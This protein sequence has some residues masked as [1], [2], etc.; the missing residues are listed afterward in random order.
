MQQIRLSHSSLE[1]LHTCE[2][3]FQ[4]DKLI[5]TDL[6]KEESEH[7][8]F[9]T[10][11]GV[12]IATYLSTAD[13]SLALYKAWLAYWPEIE[14]DGKNVPLLLHTLKLA[15]KECD[16]LLVSYEVVSF[17]RKE[18]VELSFKINISDFYYFVGHIDVVLRDKYTGIHYILEVKTTSRNLFDL[19]PLYA[20]SGQALGYS[21]ALDKIVGEKVS[22][23]GVIYLVAQ[24]GKDAKIKIHRLIY[25]KTILDR[26]NWFISL[27]MDKKQLDMMREIGIYPKRGAS[28]LSYNRPCKYF[29]VCS[30]QSFKDVP[31]EFTDDVQYQFEYSLDELITDHIERVKGL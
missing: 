6:E 13:S 15:F 28:C 23:Y 12:G 18:A 2:R 25:E 3:K 17:E 24:I 19:S 10:A 11:Y 1:V 8:S 4:L 7:F 5:E 26:L 30:L 22:S 9:G 21:I 29:G 20:N 16:D 27:L 14:T 31:K